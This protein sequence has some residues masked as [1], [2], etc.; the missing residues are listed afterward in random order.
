MSPDGH[1][2]SGREPQIRTRRLLVDLPA[3]IKYLICAEFC[4]HCCKLGA[5][6]IIAP[7]N[8]VSPLRALSETCTV[9]RE[10]AQPLLYH[11]PYIRRYSYFLRTIRDR[12]D[13]ADGVKC[14]PPMSVE[15]FGVSRSIMERFN[16]VKEMAAE[17]QMFAPPDTSFEDEFAHIIPRITRD[18]D[19]DAEVKIQ[20]ES[21][22]Q[23]AVFQTLLYTVLIASLPCLEILFIELWSKEDTWYYPERILQHAQRRLA[24][25]GRIVS[26]RCDGTFIPSLHTIIVEGWGDV[27]A[28]AEVHD[29]AERMYLQPHRF[30]AS[31]ASSLKELV[32]QQCSARKAWPEASMA[33]NVSVF[34]TL[35]NL[36]SIVFD[37]MNWGCYEGMVVAQRDASPAYLRIQQLAE[38]CINLE[39]FKIFVR[40]VEQFSS[41][42]PNRLLQSLLPACSRL[43]TLVIREDGLRPRPLP[44]MLLGEDMH[45]FTKLQE[46]SLD[47]VSFCHHWLSDGETESQAR[48]DATS[49]VDLNS[50]HLHEGG[51]DESDEYPQTLQSDSCLV[52][53]LPV[54]VKH[55][56]ILLA[57]RSRAIPDLV[58]LGIAAAAGNFPSLKHISVESHVNLR[59]IWDNM[60]MSSDGR[61][62]FARRDL[63]TGPEIQA[64]ET[65]LEKAFRGSGAVVE[66]R[67]FRIRE[68]RRSAAQ[69]A[70]L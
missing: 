17:L 25:V 33:G 49:T 37:E 10:V 69:Y 40:R 22:S 30:L 56:S 54:S 61:T 4:R 28:W 70:S 60:R 14:L 51:T 16:I 34:S 44:T 21:P 6:D 47:E 41:F 35:P 48:T 26:D 1:T 64:L 7:S 65:K 5:T 9:F 57:R 38:Q 52:D 11:I 58:H 29:T 31:C 66:V 18:V 24:R 27:R 12:S 62:S 46:L 15:I 68:F 43:E 42:S 67:S 50:H 23:R 59:E 20:F 2:S 19:N 13:L 32:F 36:K 39:S 45:S 63:T 8:N 55:L 3:E 53:I